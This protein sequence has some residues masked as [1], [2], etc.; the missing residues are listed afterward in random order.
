M[1]FP[2]NFI[3]ILND[4][5]VQISSK[6]PKNFKDIRRFLAHELTE[7]AVVNG[8]DLLYL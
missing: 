2:N 3:D 5:S 6:D 1:V 8:Q 7:P 4:R